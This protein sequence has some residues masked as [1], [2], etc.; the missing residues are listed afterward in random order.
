M[1]L[2]IEYVFFHEKPAVDEAVVFFDLDFRSPIRQET[3][4]LELDEVEPSAQF[5]PEKLSTKLEAHSEVSEE[6]Q[7]VKV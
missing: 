2:E 7:Q 6:S 4:C 3:N 5:R 1:F